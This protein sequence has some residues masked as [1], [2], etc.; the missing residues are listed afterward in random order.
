MIV[1]CDIQ[2]E[3]FVL[4]ADIHTGETVWRTIRNELPSWGTPTIY[5][6]EKHVELVTNGA[7]FIRGYDP[8]TGRELRRLGG[9]SKTTAPSPV[10]TDDLIIVASGWP[11]ER[12]IFALRPGATGDI[13]LSAK[14]QHNEFV[15]WPPLSTRT[16]HA[17][18]RGVSRRART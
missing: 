2:D 9:S 18:P 14:E 3:S 16:V 8:R 17:N 13:T 10:V 15:V 5:E 1:Q 11:P 4:A 7:N 12:P 6:R